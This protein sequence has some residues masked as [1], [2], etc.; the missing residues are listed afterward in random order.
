MG[1]QTKRDE[2]SLRAMDRD[3]QKAR[4]DTE[5]LERKVQT[6]ERIV[7]SMSPEQGVGRAMEDINKFTEEV[8]RTYNRCREN[9]KKAI[10]ILEKEFGY[11]PAFK[12]GRVL[13]P[14]HQFTATNHTMAKD[15]RKY[16]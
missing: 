16:A 1:A 5:R 15:P 2:E 9:H 12:N 14:D 6:E 8:H 4:E 13:D 10:G 11:H 3:L 7:A